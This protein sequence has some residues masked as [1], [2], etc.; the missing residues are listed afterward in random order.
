MF[1][2]DFPSMP[3]DINIDF[4]I[5]LEPSTCP[6]SV[7]PYCMTLAE[8]RERKAQI[9]QLLDKGFTRLSASSCLFGACGFKIEVMV[10]SK[11][12][13][14]Q[15]LGLPSSVT[16]IRSFVGLASYFHS[17]PW[18]GRFRILG[19]FIKLGISEK[20]GVLASIE[21]RPTF[22]KKIKSK[23]FEDESLNGLRRK[24]VFGKVQDTDL[25]ASGV[26][27]FRGR[28]CA[29]RVDNLIQKVLADSYGSWYSIHPGVI[30]MYQDL[31]QLYN[32]P[33]MK[34][35]IT[36][37]DMTL[38]EALYGRGYRSPIGRFEVGDVKPLGF[39]LVRDTL[40][41][42]SFLLDKDLQY[43]EEPVAILDHDVQKLRTKEIMLLKIQW[44]Q[45]LIEKAT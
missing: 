26:L 9:Q 42:D 39:Y 10:S 38:F 44:K 13:S 34:K 28:I 4:S 17:D 29:S 14:S 24:T 8:L 19:Q 27:N 35:D 3:P 12:Y 7:P 33:G 45:L 15:E 43:E 23:H 18:P 36:D 40:D 20:G 5:D 37:I 41:K 25:E 16:K 1:P 30:K 31:K 21:V 11:D 32:C 2:T 6:I 22:I